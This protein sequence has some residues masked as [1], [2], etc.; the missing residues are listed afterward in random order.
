[1]SLNVPTIIVG[2]FHCPN[3]N[4]FILESHSSKSSLS[5][6]HNLWPPLLN[7]KMFRYVRSF[8][9]ESNSPIQNAYERR[10]AN[11]LKKNVRLIYL[12]ICSTPFTLPIQLRP[13]NLYLMMCS[14]SIN[15]H[16]GDVCKALSSLDSRKAKGIDS[17]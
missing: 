17:M 11:Y 12:I 16:A 5:Q 8:D 10:K 14:A 13:T 9:Q 1:M 4:W 15:T 6:L 2:D 7:S 3:I